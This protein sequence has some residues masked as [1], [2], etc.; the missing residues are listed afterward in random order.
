MPILI[1]VW[2]G[3][4]DENKDNYRFVGRKVP[5]CAVRLTWKGKSLIPQQRNSA[6]LSFPA[7]MSF[8]I[9][10]APGALW[11]LLPV[12][13]PRAVLADPTLGGILLLSCKAASS[14]C[15]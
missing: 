12:S 8:F 10:Q 1:S 13:W 3:I 9:L 14:P 2:G 4:M 11:T 7:L 15:F 5:Y 6:H